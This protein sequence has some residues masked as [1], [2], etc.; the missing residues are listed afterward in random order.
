MPNFVDLEVNSIQISK[1]YLTFTPNDAVSKQFVD[2]KVAD[3]V[4]SAP[5]VLDTLKELSDALGSD[6]NFATTIA[7]NIAAEATRAQAAESKEVTDRTA[8]VQSLAETVTL[9]LTNTV[10]AIGESQAVQDASLAAEVLARQDGITNES[11]ERSAQDNLLRENI[12]SEK[13]RAEV[14][15]AA[16]A[17]ARAAKDN[18]LKEGI[19]AEVAARSLAISQETAQRELADQNES[20]ARNSKDNELKEGIDGLQSSKFEK[21]SQY[22]RRTDGHFQVEDAGYLYI[23][24]AWRISANEIGQTKKLIFEYQEADAEGTLA[25]HVGIPFIRTV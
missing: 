13:S 14:A 20:I 18:E 15:E 11:I 5:A 21:S 3:L 12:E 9:N 1:D 19:D 4:N 7:S 2:Q 23:S 6:P 24:S 25:W 10:S 22:Q 16:E 8:S 17:T